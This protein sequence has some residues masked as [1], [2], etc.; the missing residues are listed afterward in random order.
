MVAQSVTLALGKKG[1]K[2]E[3]LL[4][5]HFLLHLQQVLGLPVPPSKKDPVSQKLESRTSNK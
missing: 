5:I 3:G 2:A 4:S 1:R